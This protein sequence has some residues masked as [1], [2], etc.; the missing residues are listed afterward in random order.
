MPE[1]VCA[2]ELPIADSLHSFFIHLGKW[3]NYAH[4]IECMHKGIEKELPMGLCYALINVHVTG[5]K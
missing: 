3:G 4:E 1:R 5:N 2:S